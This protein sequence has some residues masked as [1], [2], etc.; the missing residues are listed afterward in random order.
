MTIP[1]FFFHTCLK[2]P[3]YLSNHLQRIHILLTY[4]DLLGVDNDEYL[5]F[6]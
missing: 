2:K 3:S 4:A 5:Q 6:L 1:T